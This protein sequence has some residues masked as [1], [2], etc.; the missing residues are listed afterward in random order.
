MNCQFEKYFVDYVSGNLEDKEKLSFQI[1]LESC[2]TCPQQLDEFYILHN[3]IKLRERKNPDSEVLKNYHKNL[4]SE[5]SDDSQNKKSA[6]LID[7]IVESIF[8][9]RSLRFRIAEVLGLIL[10]GIFIGWLIFYPQTEINQS[11]NLNPDYFTRPI[12]KAEVEYINYYFQAAEFLLLEI[13]N[14]DVNI[15]LNKTDIEFNKSIAQKLLIKT[16]IIHEIALRQNDPKILRFLSK[17]ELR[18]YEVSNVPTEELK[19]SMDAFHVIIDD[20]RLLDDA[21]EFQKDLI[22]FQESNTKYDSIKEEDEEK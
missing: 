9:E 6:N 16:F 10:I 4:A 21:R 5:F 7:R 11:G 15:A 18:L 3:K 13:K 19:Q 1:H 8:W 20:S 22:R 17:M 2:L 14:I 12:S